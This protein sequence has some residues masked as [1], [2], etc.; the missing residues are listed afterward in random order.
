MTEK[1]TTIKKSTVTKT[2]TKKTP[3][4]K[5]VVKKTAVKKITP[6]LLS[7]VTDALDEIKALKVQV[8]DVHTVTT[9]FDTVIIVTSTS[10]R[11]GQALARNVQ[12]KVRE[13]GRKI[14]GLEGMEEGEWILIRP[15]HLAHQ[16]KTTDFNAVL[17]DLSDRWKTCLKIRK[18]KRGDAMDEI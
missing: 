15:K 18:R 6:D 17:D 2:E 7:I 12:D 4:K 9:M 3:V 8:L 11:H 13:S 14:F 16:E 5:T 1:K 10:S